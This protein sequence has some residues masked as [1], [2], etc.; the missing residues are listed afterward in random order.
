MPAAHS[1]PKSKQAAACAP[2]PGTPRDISA[3]SR[4]GL[5]QPWKF[6][7]VALGGLTCVI[8]ITSLTNAIAFSGWNLQVPFCADR[9]EPVLE[10]ALDPALPLQKCV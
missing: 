1:S 6:G 7:N 5:A 2:E 8:L 4:S 10:P 9:K 3:P